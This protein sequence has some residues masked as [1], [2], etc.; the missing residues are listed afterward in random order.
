MERARNYV[1]NNKRVFGKDITNI[2]RR[3]K[4]NSICEK[5][6][7]PTDFRTKSRSFDKKSVL[8]LRDPIISYES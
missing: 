8:E 4:N 5:A 1:L 7:L 2:Y 3:N 6:T